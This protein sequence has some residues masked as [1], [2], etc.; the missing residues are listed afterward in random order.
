MKINQ[1]HKNIQINLLFSSHEPPPWAFIR[2]S[3]NMKDR[4][5]LDT[6]RRMSTKHKSIELSIRAVVIKRV[7][8]DV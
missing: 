7:S 4:P 3:V 8:L 1:I 6:R 5:L 2:Q